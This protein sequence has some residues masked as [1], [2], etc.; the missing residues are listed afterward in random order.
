VKLVQ[1]LPNTGHHRTCRHAIPSSAG[2]Q[3]GV[4][5]PTRADPEA[6]L[7]DS[8]RAIRKAVDSVSV[9]VEERASTV[10]PKDKEIHIPDENDRLRSHLP[11]SNLVICTRVKFKD[12]V[13]LNAFVILPLNRE[14]C[15]WSAT[16]RSADI[17]LIQSFKPCE[18]GGHHS[19]LVSF[20]S[21]SFHPQ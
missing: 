3:V 7:T 12:K 13:K 14:R 2:S 16:A 20:P 1:P 11:P 19:G 8:P 18:L 15:G 5:R 4:Q 17:G 6:P 9:V 21:K 10:Y